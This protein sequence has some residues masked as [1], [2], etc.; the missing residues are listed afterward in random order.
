MLKYI[1]YNRLNAQLIKTKYPKFSND[2]TIDGAIKELIEFKKS[3]STS[4]L[5]TVL[6]TISKEV[7]DNYKIRN[8]R[9]R[10][11]NQQTNV[12]RVQQKTLSGSEYLSLISEI[13]MPLKLVKTASQLMALE[14]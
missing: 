4:K 10:K 1:F 6:K 2:E 12:L 13:P 11:K 5:L 3:N 8:N 14:V 7:K 9:Q